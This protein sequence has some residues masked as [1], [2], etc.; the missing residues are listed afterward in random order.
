MALKIACTASAAKHQAPAR[1]FAFVTEEVRKTTMSEA[2]AG[3]LPN[4]GEESFPAYY[5][6][7]TTIGDKVVKGGK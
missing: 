5:S 4:L 3:L 7:R 2:F 6:I 1:R